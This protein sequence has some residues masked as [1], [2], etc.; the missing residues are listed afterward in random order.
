MPS[1]RREA[2]PAIPVAHVHAMMDELFEQ[3]THAARVRSLADAVVGVVQFGALGIHAIGRGLAAA[4][5]LSD[6]HAIKQVDRCVGNEKLDVAALQTSWVR[7]WCSNRTEMVVNLDWTEFAYDGH[8]ML[9]LSLQTDHGRAMPLT[10]KSVDTKTLKGRRNEYE[11]DLL[12]Q[13]RAMVPESVRLTIV[14]DRAFGDQ[15]L[16]AFLVDELRFH[17][18]I[19]FRGVVAVT[20]GDGNTVPARDRT[21]PDG[22]L[23]VVRG[24]S[25]TADKA[26][27]PLVVLVHE[28]G[29]KD[30]WCLATSRDDLAGSAVKRL[31]GKRFTCE[32]TFRDV[33]DWRF[34]FG[35]RWHRVNSLTRRDRMMLMAVLALHVLSLLGRAG[36]NAGLGRLL[37]ANTS[38]TRTLSLVRQG[39]R[40]YELIPTMPE[41]RLAL[42]MLHFE[43]LVATDVFL[44]ELF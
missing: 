25:V 44:A 22:R 14:A 26:P 24:G 1:E 13:F 3:D 28:K 41:E 6:K 36:V 29:M 19:R 7:Q 12:V 42:L 27:V 39:L 20:D 32:E 16:Y 17:D 18:I 15:K 33:K 38:K 4:K 37:K 34:G 31:Y 30:G 40:W 8:S 23:R 2:K 43:T 11:D 9:V 35:M 10:W 21:K 5:G